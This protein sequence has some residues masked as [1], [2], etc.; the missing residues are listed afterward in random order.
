MLERWEDSLS[1]S[2]LQ[3]R[4]LVILA[5][6]D[7]TQRPREGMAA[8]RAARPASWPRAPPAP[9]SR[10]APCG[11]PGRY[12]GPLLCMG[13]SGRDTVT[14]APQTPRCFTSGHNSL[15]RATT[16]VPA[17]GSSFAQRKKRKRKLLEAGREVGKGKKL[18]Q[19][20]EGAV[21]AAVE[22]VGGCAVS[23]PRQPRQ[24]AHPS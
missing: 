19:P 14:A 16:A 13:S 1:W 22:Q 8:R 24:D 2:P 4:G 10:V 15:T 18:V 21:L 23:Q 20:A 6:S 5:R 7:R 9:G 17:A 11:W 3:P 12:A